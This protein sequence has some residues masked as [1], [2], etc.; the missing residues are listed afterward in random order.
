MNGKM[1]GHRK[2]LTAVRCAQLTRDSVKASAARIAESLR[3][4]LAGETSP[5]G[6]RAVSASR[7]VGACIF[8]A[9]AALVIAAA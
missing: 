2:V 4:N 9:V 5:P 8:A 1:L 7:A 6:P 3:A